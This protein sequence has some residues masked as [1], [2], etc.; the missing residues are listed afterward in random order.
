MSE[1]A[2]NEDRTEDP[3]QRKPVSYTPLDEY[4]RQGDDHLLRGRE[5]Q[6]E[7]AMQ[8]MPLTQRPGRPLSPVHGSTPCV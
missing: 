8:G 2:E 7:Q 4:K 1:E 5:F 3:T 6:S